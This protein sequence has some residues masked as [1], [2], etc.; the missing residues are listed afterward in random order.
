MHAIRSFTGKE[1]TDKGAAFGFFYLLYAV[2]TAIGFTLIG[3]VW[4][5]LGGQTAIWVSMLGVM[6]VA[7]VHGFQQRFS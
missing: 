6:V 7:T 4:E 1:A 3:F 5:M 2:T